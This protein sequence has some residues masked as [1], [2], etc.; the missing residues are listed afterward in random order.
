LPQEPASS[1]ILGTTRVKS[2]LKSDTKAGDAASVDG[3]D[4]AGLGDDHACFA[5]ARYLKAFAG[6]AP[7][8]RS[9]SRSMI[10]TYLRVPRR[11][12]RSPRDPLQPPT[13]LQR[14][15]T[16]NTSVDEPRPLRRDYSLMPSRYLN[17]F[18]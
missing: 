15:R 17:A 9:A 12:L 3:T 7:V 18:D 10:I 1:E 11:I 8:T 13:L 14:Q 5:T 2:I 6:A 4:L 16:D